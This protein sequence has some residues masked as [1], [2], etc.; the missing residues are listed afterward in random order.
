MAAKDGGDKGSRCGFKWYIL[1]YLRISLNQIHPHCSL[2]P[3]AWMAVWRSQGSVGF[4][5]SFLHSSGHW[6][7]RKYSGTFFTPWWPFHFFIFYFSLQKCVLYSCSPSPDRSHV[8][9]IAARKKKNEIFS[10][11]VFCSKR[12]IF[13]IKYSG[14]PTTM[15]FGQMLDRPNDHYNVSEIQ[16]Y[17]FLSPA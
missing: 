10:Y 15:K 5:F 12:Q 11:H 17:I 3:S 6:S 13:L 16:L 1:D 14:V 4:F 2:L 7:T 8:H 9:D